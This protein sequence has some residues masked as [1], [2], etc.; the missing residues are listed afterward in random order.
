MIR[1]RLC[2]SEVS[3]AYC[4]VCGTPADESAGPEYA[5]Q[6]S[7]G[8][9]FA[10]PG[11]SQTSPM[12]SSTPALAPPGQPYTPPQ[13]RRGP[14][15]PILAAVLALAVLLVGFLVVQRQLA[16]T[17]V[18]PTPT[19]ATPAVPST[20]TTTSP[21]VTVP[22]IPTVAVSATPTPSGPS[23]TPPVVTVPVVTASPDEMLQLT[24]AASR[25]QL[26]AA[27]AGHA[28]VAQL[29]SKYVGIT[30]P[31]QTT[32]TG[33]HTFGAADILAEHL[34]LAGRAKDATVILADSR[35]YGAKSNMEGQ[36]YWRTMALSP[37]FTDALVVTDWCTRTFP[38]L[39]GDA[40]HN[41]CMPVQL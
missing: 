11:G 40:L 13:P 12:P 21:P 22:P 35:T 8:P 6:E 25:P 27:V 15:L 9:G 24:A 19:V 2:G 20:R 38:E 37:A 32:A 4:T 5:G 28:W 26:D 1:C 14:G 23:T 30:D 10:G 36:A 16:G 7:A 31:L 34:A 3:G 33:S 29:A 18:A 41:Q 17:A 39:S